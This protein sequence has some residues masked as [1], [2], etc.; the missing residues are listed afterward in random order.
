MFGSPDAAKLF[1]PGYLLKSRGYD[2]G[3]FGASGDGIDGVIGD[4]TKAAFNAFVASGGAAIPDKGILGGGIATG[5]LDDGLGTSFEKVPKVSD[6]ASTDDISVNNIKEYVAYV[7]AQGDTISEEHQNR[8]NRILWNAGYDTSDQNEAVMSYLTAS[9]ETNQK[10]TDFFGNIRTNDDG[11]MYVDVTRG[12]VTKRIT[13][14]NASSP[15]NNPKN[16]SNP[17]AYAMADQNNPMSQDQAIR[18]VDFAAYEAVMDAMFQTRDLTGVNI[19]GGYRPVN[20]IPGQSL[21]HPE[22]RGLDINE[23]QV[24]GSPSPVSIS[25]PHSRG[26]AMTPEHSVVA[27][28][29]N[30]LRNDSRVNQVLNPWREYSLSENNGDW[31]VNDGMTNRERRHRDHLHFGINR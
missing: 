10:R 12:D 24:S 11:D 7:H 27:N 21:V 13:W 14:N 5:V 15:V 3:S 1:H 4:K 18:S 23:I 17:F 2:L 16:S 19:S 28:L 25:L 20:S 29:S 30:N 9:D 8:M 26:A 31:Q 22:G 6:K